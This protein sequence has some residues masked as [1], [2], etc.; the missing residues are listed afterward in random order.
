MNPLFRITTE[1]F[2]IDESN[3]TIMMEIDDGFPLRR[4]ADTIFGPTING[5]VPDTADPPYADVRG[6][7]CFIQMY[8]GRLTQ[9]YSIKVMNNRRPNYYT[10]LTG[11][12]LPD[13]ATVTH[14]YY[15]ERPT[16]EAITFIDKFRR[17]IYIPLLQSQIKQII[18]CVDRKNENSRDSLIDFFIDSLNDFG[19]DYPDKS[20]HIL[21]PDTHIHAAVG[22]N[23]MFWYI[24]THD[25]E[26]GLF[27]F[28]SDDDDIINTAGVD[29]IN[30][31][32]INELLN[33]TGDEGSVYRKILLFDPSFSRRDVH[34]NDKGYKHYA[35]WT[36]AFSPEYYNGLS[37]PCCPVE[38]E[39][40]DVFNRL[41]QHPS[42]IIN[43]ASIEPYASRL[44]A[45]PAYHYLGPNR[46]R[47]TYYELYATRDVINYLN[48]HNS[49]ES[50]KD[51]TTNTVISSNQESISGKY[52][53]PNKASRYVA[54]NMED[55][56]KFRTVFGIVNKDKPAS[57]KD[58]KRTPSLTGLLRRNTY[59]DNFN[60]DI[61]MIS[62]KAI[63]LFGDGD[64][65]E[66]Y[67]CALQNG[68]QP[69]HIPLHKSNIENDIDLSVDVGN[70]IHDTIG[71]YDELLT[72]KDSP[73]T[74][75]DRRKI[76][77]WNS[78]YIR[79]YRKRGTHVPLRVFGGDDSV[80]VSFWVV[81]LICFFIGAVICLCMYCFSGTGISMFRTSTGF[82][83]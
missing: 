26:N 6:L 58:S 37:F 70:E 83:K 5:A 47:N 33:G 35:S 1:S 8:E 24:R 78:H 61:Y 21:V 45:E 3:C 49:V 52:Y 15:D 41:M 2:N 20:V 77:K 11:I 67:G 17:D 57:Q 43:L 62:Y 63:L 65:Q 73:L 76:D 72:L 55:Q 50:V 4:T 59:S 34:R 10:N 19:K 42:N 81:L 46:L 38:K 36:Y 25:E 39:D 28:G 68:K 56:S 64:Y 66:L 30:E 74:G 75:D 13:K 29:T 71:N 7:G 16:H 80:Q 60:G 22:R 48:V 51:L 9:W 69:H 23:L 12:T 54:H 27:W 31:Y 18:I 53:Y 44:K 32:I 79:K 40:L 82:I 14:E